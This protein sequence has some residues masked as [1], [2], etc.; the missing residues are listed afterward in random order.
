MIL[1]LRNI[2]NTEK[3]YFTKGKPYGRNRLVKLYLEIFKYSLS[4]LVKALISKFINGS[5][6]QNIKN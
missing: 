6:V 2:F 3:H 5:F 1:P 4:Q